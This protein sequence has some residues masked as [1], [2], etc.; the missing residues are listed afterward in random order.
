M[1]ISGQNHYDELQEH[2]FSRLSFP[3]LAYGDSLLSQFSQ[4][5]QCEAFSNWH[6]LS[7]LKEDSASPVSYSGIYGLSEFPMHTDMANWRLPPRY[8]VLWAESGSLDVST[9]LLDCREI[10]DASERK[11][12]ARALVKPRRPVR[13]RLPIMR[14][15]ENS[16]STDYY[17]RWDT[18]FLKPAS[19]AGDDGMKLVSSK[20]EAGRSYD[21]CLSRPGDGVIIDNWRM[22]H[23]RS[24]VKEKDM[25]RRLRRAYLGSAR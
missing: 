11:I 19:P 16:N 20:L 25:K 3:D 7:P 6:T 24:S 12:L 21:V 13:G 9:P 15:I 2:G 8:L 10:F 1:S 4:E 23:G 22:L 18:M 14:L 5:L 17:H